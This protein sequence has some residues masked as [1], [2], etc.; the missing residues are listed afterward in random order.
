MLDRMLAGM[1][2]PRLYIY[3]SV[4]LEPSLEH[5]IIVRGDE[6]GISI[7]VVQISPTASRRRRS[8]QPRLIL[9]TIIV[10]LNNPRC[11]E[12]W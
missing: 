9:I 8:N 3:H 7:E 6:H 12:W 1:Y 5:Q 4:H 11:F 10:L 2:L